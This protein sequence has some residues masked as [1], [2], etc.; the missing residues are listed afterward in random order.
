MESVFTFRAVE[1]G[2]R[3]CRRRKR[4]T[5]NAQRYEQR[6]LD[7]DP[8]QL[9]HWRERIADCLAERLQLRLKSDERPRPLGD[10]ADFLGYIVRPHYRLVRRRVIGHLRERLAAFAKAHVHGESLSLPS[11]P[12][13][14]LRAQRVAYAYVAEEGYLPGGMKRRVLRFLF[15]PASV[16]ETSTA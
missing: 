11:E 9:R 6:L 13:E 5:A 14:H 1:Q 4:G 12:R 3:D 8:D 10:G 2:Y 16:S 15:I 7:H